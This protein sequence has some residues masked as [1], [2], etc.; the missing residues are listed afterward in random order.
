MNPIYDATKY[1]EM[2]ASVQRSAQ[3]HASYGDV[4]GFETTAKAWKGRKSDFHFL[5]P[6][7]EG[8]KRRVPQ[9]RDQYW[10]DLIEEGLV[11]EGYAEGSGNAIRWLTQKGVQCVVY[12]QALATRQAQQAD[13]RTIWGEYSADHDALRS[14]WD[15]Y[16]TIWLLELYEGVEDVQN[17]NIYREYLDDRVD[18]EWQSAEN[19]GAGWGGRT[20]D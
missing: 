16:G 12:W 9:E 3:W 2:V 15:K 14:L 18:E 20:G 7:L 4:E 19:W 6:L 1:R 10:A 8:P 13:V 5:C 11:A 17:S